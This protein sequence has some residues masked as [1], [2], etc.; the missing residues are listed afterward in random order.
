MF[1]VLSHWPGRCWVWR[2]KSLKSSTSARSKQTTCNL[3]VRTSPHPGQGKPFSWGKLTMLQEGLR[4]L[5]KKGRN[6]SLH[7]EV[8]VWRK[9]ARS[10]GCLRPRTKRVATPQWTVSDVGL[11]R[12]SYQP[13]QSSIVAILVITGCRRLSE[14]PLKPFR[15]PC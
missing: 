13:R 12:R 11:A 9:L 1:W 6:F 10:H 14:Q 3:L 5:C 4:S 7:L 15:R 8:G 2:A